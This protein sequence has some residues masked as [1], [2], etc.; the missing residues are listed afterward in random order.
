[1]NRKGK[2]YLEKVSKDEAWGKW[3]AL[4]DRLGC[5]GI[6]REEMV[7]AQ[8]SMGRVTARAIF[9]RVS[10]PA[11]HSSAMDGIAVRA[12]DTFGAS[13]IN[14]IRLRL[15]EDTVHIDTGDPIPFGFDAV[16]MIE[17]VDQPEEGVL[18][19]IKAASPWQHIRPLGEDMVETEMVLPQRH[20]IRPEDLG[21]LLASGHLEVTVRVK[22]VVGI[23]P[24]GTELVE[25]PEELGLGKI[26][27]TNSW[28]VSALVRSWGG[29]AIRYQLVPDEIE[30]IRKAMEDALAEVDVLVVDAGTSAGREDYTALLLEELGEVAVHGV[31]MKP[32]KPVILGTANSRPV[33]GLPGFPLANHRAAVEFIRPMLRRLLGLPAYPGTTTTAHMVRK[34]ASEAGMEEYIQVKLGRVEEKVMAVPLARGSG[35]SMSL[36]RS[37]GE[38][39][40]PRGKEGFERMEPVEVLLRSPDV[41]VD[42]TILVTGSHD[43]CL[44]VLAEE[45][46]RKDPRFTLASANIGS[47]G[48]I[49][50]VA[51]RNTHVAGTHL[52]DPETGEYNAPFVLKYL[53]PAEV[54]L[55]NLAYREQGLLVPSGNPRGISGIVDLAKDGVIFINRQKG[56]GTR[57]LLDHLLRGEGIEPGKVGGYDREVFTHTAAAAAVAGGTADVGLGVLAAARALKLDFIPLARERY[58]LLILLSFAQSEGFHVMMAAIKDSGFRERVEGLGGYDLSRSGEKISL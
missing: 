19:I 41:E 25:R 55:I 50:A 27:E 15:G 2:V 48:G 26:M 20:M 18:E 11:F 8:E 22:P 54:L 58:D 7:P 45:V 33:I 17:D 1:M 16:I 52:L 34:V 9:A 57:L 6:S 23:I 31:A 3:L 5:P 56:S 30:R 37:D 32:G 4:C 13:E 36:V 42:N 51:S 10:S 35:I 39:R 24:T 14:P 47:L 28:M 12:K 40:V 46:K 53:D 43:I 49:M 29:E 38:V 21:A 44:D